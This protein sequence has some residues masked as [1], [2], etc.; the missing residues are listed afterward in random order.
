MDTQNRF[1]ALSKPPNG[2]ENS[3]ISPNRKKYISLLSQNIKFNKWIWAWNITSFIFYYSWKTLFHT[4]KIR[5]R[6]LNFWWSKKKWS[7]WYPKCISTC[8]IWC[9]CK[10][11]WFTFGDWG[12]WDHSLY[13]QAAWTKPKSDSGYT[14]WWFGILKWMYRNKPGQ[15]YMLYFK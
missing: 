14:Y 2:R 3:P 7:L 13:S 8:W 12:R 5:C 9:S 1:L 15:K 11:G 10:T 6:I 4:F